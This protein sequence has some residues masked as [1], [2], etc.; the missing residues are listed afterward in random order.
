MNRISVSVC[1]GKLCKLVIFFIRSCYHFSL[2]TFH[3]STS[4]EGSLPENLDE[5]VSRGKFLQILLPTIAILCTSLEKPCHK[6]RKLAQGKELRCVGHRSG[7]GHTGDGSWVTH[8]QSCVG[9]L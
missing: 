2:A 4:Q 9:E 3:S 6:E 7:G 8:A 1:S 5:V